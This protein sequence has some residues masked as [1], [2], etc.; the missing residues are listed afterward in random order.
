MQASSLQLESSVITR[1][2]IEANKEF[3]KKN[4]PQLRFIDFAGAGFESDVEYGPAGEEPRLFFLK[5]GIRLPGTEQTPTPYVVDIQLI[6]IFRCTGPNLSKDEAFVGV[7]GPAVL[8]GSIREL[9]TQITSRGPLPGLILP[10]VHFV[11]PDE[12]G[13]TGRVS[14]DASDQ[15]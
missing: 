4:D 13:A 7:N 9:V 10:T 5:L 12:E 2:R 11:P 1:V 14:Q 3:A 6:G 15:G 8:Y